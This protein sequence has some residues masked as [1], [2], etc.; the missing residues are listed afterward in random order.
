MMTSEG[1]RSEVV[2]R[3]QNLLVT[4]TEI[5]DDRQVQKLQD[6]GKCVFSDFFIH[7]SFLILST[8]AQFLIRFLIFISYVECYLLRQITNIC[9]I[10]LTF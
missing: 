7:F 3:R 6:T 1:K 9:E 2:V 10:T 4:A 5:E 8:E